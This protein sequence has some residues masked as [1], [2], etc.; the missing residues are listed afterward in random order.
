MLYLIKLVIRYQCAVYVNE[1]ERL[2]RKD[3]ADQVNILPPNTF[4]GEAVNLVLSWDFSANQNRLFYMQRLTN[5][6]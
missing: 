4:R 6:I 5:L 3:I 1:I 2:E